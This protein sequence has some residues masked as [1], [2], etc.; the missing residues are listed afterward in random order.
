MK[1]ATEIHAQN[2][3]AHKRCSTW[4]AVQMAALKDVNI[5]KTP[6]CLEHDVLWC[7]TAS[8]TS[9]KISHLLGTKDDM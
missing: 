1:T 9:L 3:R 5:N 4:T 2:L 6:H 8:V 7:V